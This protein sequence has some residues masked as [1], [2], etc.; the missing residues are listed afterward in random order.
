VQRHALSGQG[1]AHVRSCEILGGHPNLHPKWKCLSRFYW[2]E[3]D[4]GSVYSQ[5]HLVEGL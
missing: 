3:S 5:F 2:S 4:T 1:L